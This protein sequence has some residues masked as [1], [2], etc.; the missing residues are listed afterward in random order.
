MGKSFYLD[1]QMGQGNYVVVSH[2]MEE[3]SVLLT[4]LWQTQLGG[5][6][7]ITDR[8]YR[9]YYRATTK[10]VISPSVTLINGRTV[11]GSALYLPTTKEKHLLTVY[12]CANGGA[13][14][15]MVQG[16]L[17]SRIKKW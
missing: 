1:S 11:R 2:N 12:T 8:H 13:T 14:R 7:V 10:K 15:L 4:N 9:Y 17:T 6:M 3:P 5:H 16:Q